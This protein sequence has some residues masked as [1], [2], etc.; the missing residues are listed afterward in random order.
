[1]RRWIEGASTTPPGARA[2]RPKGALLVGL[3]K[4]RRRGGRAVALAASVLA[5]S[6]VLAGVA[7]AQASRIAGTDEGLGGA[8]GIFASPHACCPGQS[9]A[10]TVVPERSGTPT[11]VALS[12]S[13]SSSV[14]IRIGLHSSGPGGAPGPLLAS[15]TVPFSSFGPSHF[16]F[17]DLAVSGWPRMEAGQTYVVSAVVASAPGSG[18]WRGAAP[19]ATVT[20]QWIGEMPAGASEPDWTF[21]STQQTFA[22]RIFA[23]RETRITAHGLVADRSPLRANLTPSATL[24]A[25]DPQEPLGG[26][27]IRFYS[28]STLLCTATTAAN[29]RAACGVPLPLVNGLRSAG[30]YRATFA[31]DDD[32]L[33]SSDQGTLVE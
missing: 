27:Q 24:V 29:G 12:M 3:V 22:I 16:V 10:T 9:A 18:F 17:T 31:G 4:A 7:Q 15:T 28:G 19:T 1:M 26:K 20:R 11:R 14:P 21:N 23:P 33:A 5:A 2:G 30:N 32:Y 6:L 25:L 8:A 13:S